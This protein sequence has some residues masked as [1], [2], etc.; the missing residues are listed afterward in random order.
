MNV[1]IN[2]VPLEKMMNIEGISASEM[3]IFFD[4]LAYDYA[5]SVIELQMADLSP[6]TVPHE[7]TNKFLYVLRELREVFRQM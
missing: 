7:N 1:K 5:I 6:R 3:S 4:E 2:L